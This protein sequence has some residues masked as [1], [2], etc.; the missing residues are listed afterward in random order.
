MQ[1][2]RGRNATTV[3]LLVHEG[4]LPAAAAAR[5]AEQNASLPLDAP[6]AKTSDISQR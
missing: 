1:D 5:L 3:P 6:A 4:L 2:F